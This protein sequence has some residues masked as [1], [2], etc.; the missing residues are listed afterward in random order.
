MTIIKKSI[1]MDREVEV[2]LCLLL[3]IRYCPDY[4][5]INGNMLKN[6]GT[7]S[8]YFIS[9]LCAT[10]SMT[11]YPLEAFHPEIFYEKLFFTYLYT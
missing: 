8:F 5:R 6:N 7:R 1:W 2:E 3:S 4:M 9:G 10:F 11:I